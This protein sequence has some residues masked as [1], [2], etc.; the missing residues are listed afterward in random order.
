MGRFRGCLL[1]YLWISGQDGGVVRSAV[2]F[3][4][5]ALRRWDDE[6]YV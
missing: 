5:G 6:G 2:G 4:V 3:P 1:L